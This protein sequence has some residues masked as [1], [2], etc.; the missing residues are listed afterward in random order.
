M[1]YRV[2]LFQPYLRQFVLNFGKILKEGEF[3]S[4]S[5][6]PTR[7]LYKILPNFDKEIERMKTTTWRCRLR[8]LLGIPNVRIRYEKEGD[9]LFTYGTLLVSNKPYCAYLETGLSFYNYDLGIGKHP[10]ARLIVSLLA[11]HPNCH[12]I[13]FLSE[14]AKKSF[15]SSLWYPKFVRERLEKKMTVIYPL[16]L[17]ETAV[18]PPKTLSGTFKILSVGMFY[19]KGGVELVKAFGRLQKQYPNI[20]L[21]IVTP[22]HTVKQEDIDWVKS[23][24]HINLQDA[25]LGAEEMRALYRDHHVFCLPTYRDGFGLVLIEAIAHGMPL[26][27]TDQYATSEMVEEKKSGFI[28]RY[29][30][31]LDYIPETYQIHGKYYN[32]KFFYADLFRFQ[33]EGKFKSVE[34][35]LYQSIEQFLIHPELLEA[36]SKHSL[37]L[38]QRKF[39]PDVIGKQLEAVLLKALTR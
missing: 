4:K 37:A 16:P 6:P 11:M 5:T 13:I 22:L 26:I 3:I 25:V 29:H 10:I 38:Y 28:F 2:T 23:I 15:F 14:A 32:P 1:K 39:H 19:M 12:S 27:I 34:D 9:L 24:P 30:P 33:K 36:F 31:L 35:F 21:T 20:E 7:T 18:H 17:I 8:R